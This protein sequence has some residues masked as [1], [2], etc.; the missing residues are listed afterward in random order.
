MSSDI[1]KIENIIA[2]IYRLYDLEDKISLGSL[3]RGDNEIYDEIHSIIK[4]KLK[5]CMDRLK[6]LGDDNKIN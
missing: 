1:D 6:E 5:G 4:A 3:T 2:D